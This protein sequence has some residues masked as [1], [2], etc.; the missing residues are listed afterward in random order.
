M[1]V[2]IRRNRK[3]TEKSTGLKIGHYETAKKS[4]PQKAAATKAKERAAA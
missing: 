1:R 4:P 3:P 2:A